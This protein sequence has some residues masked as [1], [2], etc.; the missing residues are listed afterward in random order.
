M[1]KVQYTCVHMSNHT[2]IWF[3]CTLGGGFD[4]SPED[5][6]V[7]LPSDASVYGIF[8][9]GYPGADDLGWLINGSQVQEG[10]GI[11]TGVQTIN[12]RFVKTLT[13]KPSLRFNGIQIK[14]YA[15][16]PDRNSVCESDGVHLYVHEG[17]QNYSPYIHVRIESTLVILLIP[18]QADVDTTKTEIPDPSTCMFV[19]SALYSTHTYMYMYIRQFCHPYM[20]Y[21]KG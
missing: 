11:T 3:T 15:S 7:T 14:C 4:P 5:V 20:S 12:N 8:Y 9:C 6:N 1:Y 10:N 19:T 17:S 18:G 16:F 2:T 13:I 21:M